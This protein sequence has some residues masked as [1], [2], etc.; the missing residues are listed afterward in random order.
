M[1]KQDKWTGLIRQTE[2]Y[3]IFV[4]PLGTKV[5]PK[6][7]LPKW[8]KMK[9]K[10]SPNSNKSKPLTKPVSIL[11]KACRYFQIFNI[12]SK[13]RGFFSNHYKWSICNMCK[14]IKRTAIRS[15]SLFVLQISN[16]A[17]ATR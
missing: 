1:T 13:R 7:S 12:K 5:S 10:I 15:D 14:S 8:N 17:K 2:F 11:Q 3:E 6:K 16:K 9:A 4:K